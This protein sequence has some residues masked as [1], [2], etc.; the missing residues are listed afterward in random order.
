M[1]RCGMELILYFFVDAIGDG[2]DVGV[3]ITFTNDEKIRWRIAEFAQV[4]LHD[5]FAFF[6]PD[7]LYDEVVQLFG[8]RLLF[9]PLVGNA[10]QIKIDNLKN[11][12]PKVVEKAVI[13]RFP[14]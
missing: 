14:F 6:V 4:K 13:A 9:C 10:D 3:G 1:G 7:S 8:L 12:S 2:F 5:I 11:S